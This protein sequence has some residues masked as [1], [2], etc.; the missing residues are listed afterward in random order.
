MKKLKYSKSLLFSLI[1]SLIGLISLLGTMKGSPI[2]N[3]I[4]FLGILI[5]FPI[6]FISFALLF[7]NGI[8]VWAVLLIQTITFFVLWKIVTKIFSHTKKPIITVD[9]KDKANSDG[10]PPTKYI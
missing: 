2:N 4:F 8:S 9:F 6:D 3:D 7:T 10:N 1:Y 5:C